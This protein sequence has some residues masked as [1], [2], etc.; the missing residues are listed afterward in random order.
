MEMDDRMQAA[1]LEYELGLKEA[2]LEAKMQALEIQKNYLLQ[3]L[4]STDSQR[5]LQQGANQLNETILSKLTGIHTPLTSI[6]I[7]HDEDR[8]TVN[9]Q[10]RSSGY[11]FPTRSIQSK[12]VR[13]P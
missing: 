12:N 9:G 2:A 5:R 7:Q 6:D 13:R 10:N 3:A 11:S 1:E 4:Q 8:S